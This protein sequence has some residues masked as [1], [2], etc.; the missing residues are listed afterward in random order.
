MERFVSELTYNV[1]MGTLNPTHLLAHSLEAFAV[2][3]KET[4]RFANTREMMLLSTW[5]LVI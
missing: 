4:R 2:T 1:L 5:C 3:T